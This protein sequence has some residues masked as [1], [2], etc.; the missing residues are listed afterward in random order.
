LR[1]CLTPDA[2]HY[3]LSYVGAN[4]G[5]REDCLD[6]TKT[7]RELKPFQNLLKFSKRA[8]GRSHYRFKQHVGK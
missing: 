4:N 7:L 3:S 8:K 5:R 6:E 1:G 2:S